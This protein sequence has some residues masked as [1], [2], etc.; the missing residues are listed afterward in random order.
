MANIER[1]YDKNYLCGAMFEEGEEKTLTIRQVKREELHIPNSNQ[2]N[3]MPV[4]YFKEKAPKKD[5]NLKILLDKNGKQRIEEI[6]PMGINKTNKNILVKLY[7]EESTNYIGK[8]ITTYFDPNVK[9][10]GIKKGGLR[11]RQF[12]PTAETI[13]LCT[14]CK[15]PII[16]GFGKTAQGMADYTLTKYGVVLCADCATKRKAAVK[17][18]VE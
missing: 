18:E 14:D 10:G 12:V 1:F 8:Q 4:I 15:K 7:G 6:M 3:V 11:I 2:T 16:A 17:G 13:I 9:A 5:E